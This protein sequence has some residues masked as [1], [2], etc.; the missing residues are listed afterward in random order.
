[1]FA[2]PESLEK[3]NLL[4]KDK[5]QRATSVQYVKDVITMMKELDGH[6]VS[7]VPCTVGKIIPN[8]CI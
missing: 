4:A 8:N 6:M 1:M 7:V 3:R 5:A 2:H